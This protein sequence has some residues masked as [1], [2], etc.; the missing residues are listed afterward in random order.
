MTK[1]KNGIIIQRD[2]KNEDRSDYLYEN[3]GEVDKMYGYL[4]RFFAE[5]TEFS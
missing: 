1:I 3:K 4:L 2:V 5:N